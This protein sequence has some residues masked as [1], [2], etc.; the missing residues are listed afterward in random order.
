MKYRQNFGKVLKVESLIIGIVIVYVFACSL[1]IY[2]I[3]KNEV[4]NNGVG[5][6]KEAS[7][8]SPSNLE[9]TEFEEEF[10]GNTQLQQ[11]DDRLLNYIRHRVLIPPPAQTEA[12]VLS[13]KNPHKEPAQQEEIYRYVFKLLGEMKD[14]FFIECGGNDGELYSNTLALELR[15]GWTGLLVEPL[16]LAKLRTRG[17]YVWIAPI[18]LSGMDMFR[19]NNDDLMTRLGF[20][21]NVSFTTKCFP[22][23]SLLKAINITTVDYFSLD[24]EG[25][26]LSV[27]K[28]IPWDRVHIKVIS[29]EVPLWFEER[30]SVDS[31]MKSVGYKLMTY[32]SNMYSHDNIYIHSSVQHDA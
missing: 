12:V 3:S 10:I 6:L 2:S 32:I 24:I 21:E 13:L 26:E 11:D 16:P 15:H 31:Y 20:G 7:T 28:T 1:A 27:L 29:I 19:P 17:R 23:F 8:L 18:C 14:G 22:V 25:A 9:P 5:P 30:K 4:I